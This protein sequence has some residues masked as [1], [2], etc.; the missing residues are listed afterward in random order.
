M[1][2]LRQIMIGE[3]TT[4]IG[5]VIEIGT[6]IVGII[7]HLQSTTG[8]VEG[9]PAGSGIGQETETV[10]EKETENEI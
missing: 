2:T 9:N 7:H 10:I 6:M 3:M 4:G 5:T 8:I 1:S